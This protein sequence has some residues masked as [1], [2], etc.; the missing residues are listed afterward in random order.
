MPRIF[1]VYKT[2]F[3]PQDKTA[4]LAKASTARQL[5]TGTSPDTSS[6]LDSQI[7]LA[8]LS[9]ETLIETARDFVAGNEERQRKVLEILQ[10]ESDRAAAKKAF[11]DILMEYGYRCPS[12]T[13]ASGSVSTVET[14]LFREC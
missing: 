11:L 9:K 14:Q 7:H 1:R 4:S 6:V 10:T 8:S 3:S 2:V 5:A 13:Y 12:K